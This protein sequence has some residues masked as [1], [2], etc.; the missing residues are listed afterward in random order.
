MS[1]DWSGIKLV[2][3]DVD[4]TL[5]DQWPLRWDM[6]RALIADSIQ[7][8][9]L[10]TIRILSTFR[11]VR[12]SLGDA[13]DA[14]ALS[15]Q[16][17]RTAR[18]RGCS[19]DHVRALVE[20]WIEQEPLSRLRRRRTRGAS[21]LFASLRRNGR[22]IAAW[23]DYPMESKLSTLG[24][25]AD[26]SVCSSDPAVDRLKPDPTGL[27]LILDRTATSPDEA[28]VVGDR[29]DRDWEAARA[30]S[31]S[32]LIRSFRKNERSPT[33]RDFRDPVFAP[34]L[35]EAGHA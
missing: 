9:S 8:R 19:E 34:I 23:S 11:R 25:E 2:V 20:R 21:E 12:E 5:Y 26:V 27:R 4:G 1:V 18:N 35:T 3:F 29:F 17:R 33:F 28:I 32:T 6:A 7:Q 16:F 31:V 22:L 15:E 14:D 30:I 10:D 24:L 13:R